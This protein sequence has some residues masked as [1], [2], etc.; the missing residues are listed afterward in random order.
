MFKL[1]S[2]AVSALFLFSSFAVAGQTGDYVGV[3][4]GVLLSTN[5]NVTDRDGSS[6]KLTY[7]NISIPFSVYLGHQFGIGFRAEEELFY[8][9]TN[10]NKFS[11]LSNTYN[12]DSNVWA[13]GAMSNVY[14]DWYHDVKEMEDTYF[15]PYIGLGIGLVDVNM[16]EATVNVFKLWN[17]DSDIGIAYQI[18]I[19]NTSRITDKISLDVSYR[20][21]TTRN[22]N[23]DRINFNYSN[24]NVLLGVRYFFR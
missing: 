11:F 14:Y 23:I 20:F 8:K 12:I 21:F 5:S 22:V 18:M 7:E 15:S 24:Q 19:G 6:G 13:L 3:S 16:S 17:S 10:A 2:A 1:F 9:K 4:S